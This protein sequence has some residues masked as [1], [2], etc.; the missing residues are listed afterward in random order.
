MSRTRDTAGI[1]QDLREAVTEASSL[2]EA[3]S[4][5]G[6][7]AIVESGTNANGSYIRWENGEQVCRRDTDSVD[8]SVED[9]YLFDYP[10]SFSGFPVCGWSARN[11]WST[12]ANFSAAFGS[13]VTGRSSQWGW[14][15]N[16]SGSAITEMRI[17]LLA[18]GFW[19]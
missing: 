11:G 4:F 3:V 7:G 16:G 2:D 19:K 12:T 9:Q 10:A 18:W 13:A 8:S 15:C 1:A 6:R 5:V 17:N 14:I